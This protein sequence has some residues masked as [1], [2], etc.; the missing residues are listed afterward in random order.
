MRT[1][2]WSILAAAV[3]V[4]ATVG[5]SLTALA[6]TAEADNRHMVAQPTAVAPAEP[7]TGR[8]QLQVMGQGREWLVLDTRTGQVQHWTPGRLTEAGPTYEVRTLEASRTDGR[9]YRHEVIRERAER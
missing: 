9:G 1:P 7:A 5:L 2:R 8:Y 6:A 3:A 4:A